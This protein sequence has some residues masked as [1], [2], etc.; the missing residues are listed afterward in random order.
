VGFNGWGVCCCNARPN[1]GSSTVCKQWHT[2]NKFKF[3]Y[4]QYQQHF[5]V[6]PVA[7]G[8]FYFP[9]KGK[10]DLKHLTSSLA[11]SV[12][13]HLHTLSKKFKYVNGMLC[14]T[15]LMWSDVHLVQSSTVYCKNMLATIITFIFLIGLLYRELPLHNFST[16]KLQCV[17]HNLEWIAGARLTHTT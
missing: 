2:L 11:N 10:T 12:F 1:T 6:T 15:H 17:L 8:W 7:L 14:K 13:H 3:L 4:S 9:L 16:Q 5:N